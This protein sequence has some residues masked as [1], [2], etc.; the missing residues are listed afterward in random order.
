[1]KVLIVE[2]D[3]IKKANIEKEI[4]CFENVEISFAQS[5]LGAKRFIQQETFDLMILDI[6][7]PLSDEDLLAGI[8]EENGGYLLYRE[9]KESDIF[10]KPNHIIL[11]TSFADLQ[12][13]YKDDVE[14]GDF[15]IAKYGPFESEWKREIQNKVKYL[16]QVEVDRFKNRKFDY[17]A[18][19]ITVTDIEFECF[20]LI[21]ENQK[22]LK[23]DY[24]DTQYLIGNLNGNL[25][26]KVVLLKQQQMG[27]TAASVSTVKVINNFKPKYVIM[28][29]IAAGIKDSVELLDVVIASEIVEFTSGKIIKS[30]TFRE[31]FKPEPKYMNIRP[32]LKEIFVNDFKED[33]KEICES[34]FYI[35]NNFKGFNIVFG[36][37]VSGPF[38]LQNDLIIKEFI[39]PH[40]RKIKALDMES[41]G[42]I[43]ASENSFTP[44]PS[45][46]VCKA[47]SDFAD[48]AKSDVYQRNAA[49]NSA[50]IVERLLLKYLN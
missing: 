15:R 18:A 34:N 32:E 48:E 2:D 3:E 14:R 19:I 36:P 23:F 8:T 1:M 49:T 27:L 31:S 4:L 28:G 10:M 16:L 11:L 47:I 39:L 5:I 20:K 29:G 50:A 37:M 24:D 21:I 12:L 6:N 41:Y 17:F 30:K 44:K 45:V 13:K 38:V 43:Y 22:Y 7:L 33:L 46:L 35:E 9:I 26:K 25:G 40:N 42:V